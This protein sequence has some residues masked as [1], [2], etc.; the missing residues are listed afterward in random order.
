MGKIRVFISSVQFE[1]VRERQMLFSYLMTDALLGLFFEPFIFENLPASEQSPARTYLD[2]VAKCDIYIGLFGKEYGLE[3]ENDISPTEHEFN[4]A[5][6]SNKT[7][8]IFLSNCASADR[9]PNGKELIN[10]G[11]KES[12]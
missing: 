12:A 6:Q 2:Q 3:D 1:F 9:H 7:R 4:Q 10:H 5:A 11:I 8:L